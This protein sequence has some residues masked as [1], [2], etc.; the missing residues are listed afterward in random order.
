MNRVLSFAPR[1]RAIT[2]TNGHKK[3]RLTIGVLR[4]EAA[5]FFS[6]ES[7]HDEPCL[8]G[9]TDGKAVGTYLE[10]K[11][12]DLLDAKYTF[13]QGSSAKGLDFPALNVDMKVTS[14]KQPQSSSPFKSAR[15]KIYGLGYSLL[16][17]I[18]R[19]TDNDS[20]QT[21]RLNILHTI[22]IDESRTADYQITR[23]IREIIDN[24]GNTDDLIAFLSDRNPPIDDIGV[25]ELA[26]ELLG[27]PP[28]LGYLTIPNALQWRI[29]YK[30]VIKKSDTVRG[31]LRVR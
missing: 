28:Q 14:I 2:A 23:D 16:V 7:D 26:E 17:F 31:I 30:R 11:F 24:E 5:A 18:Y 3:P 9:V 22:F 12:R 29:Q 6:R 21:A 27:N 4:T 13:E 8:Y 1:Y 25:A 20:T 10:R 15:Q 19:K